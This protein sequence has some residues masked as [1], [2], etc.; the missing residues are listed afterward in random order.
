MSTR[1]SEAKN[2]HKTFNPISGGLSVVVGNHVYLARF[3]KK[4]EYQKASD[5]KR[6]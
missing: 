4:D 1:N 3:S 6:I 5:V 2:L